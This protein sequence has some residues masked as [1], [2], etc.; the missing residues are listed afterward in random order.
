MQA[1]RRCFH[2]HKQRILVLFFLYLVLFRFC[3][4]VLEDAGRSQ[5]SWKAL[6]VLDGR[7]VEAASMSNYL[8]VNTREIQ[9]NSKGPGK[10]PDKVNKQRNC[11]RHT[12]LHRHNN[13]W[14]L[15]AF[16]VFC[17]KVPEGPGRSRRSRMGASSRPKRISYHLLVNPLNAFTCIRFQ[18]FL[19]LDAITGQATKSHDRLYLYGLAL[20]CTLAPASDVS[21]H[22]E[23]ENP[24]RRV[25][26]SLMALRK[27]ENR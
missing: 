9:T 2:R 13:C 19:S 25:Q 11:N 27:G 10:V 15:F 18:I 12:P 14:Y 23:Q 3:V 20:W 7:F 8:F 1:E 21:R 24:I 16:F 5:R 17:V 22:W 4:K 6:E 26:N